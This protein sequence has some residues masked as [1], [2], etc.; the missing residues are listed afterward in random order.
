MYLANSNATYVDNV[1]DATLLTNGVAL[2]NTPTA[3]GGWLQIDPDREQIVAVEGVARENALSQARALARGHYRAP[4]VCP[5][6][7]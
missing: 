2:E 7:S 1:A 3:L 4:Y 6:V 5:E